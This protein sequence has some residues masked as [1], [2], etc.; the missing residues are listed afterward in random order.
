M[1]AFQKADWDK[2]RQRGSCAVSQ[3]RALWTEQGLYIREIREQ[4]WA[5]ESQSESNSGRESQ[6]EAKRVGE[7]ASESQCEPERFAKNFSF[8]LE[9]LHLWLSLDNSGSLPGSLWKVKLW[10]FF[11]I[12]YIKY[13]YAWWLVSKK[14]EWKSLNKKENSIKGLGGQ[15]ERQSC[16]QRWGT[17]ASLSAIST[18][19][20]VNTEAENSKGRKLKSSCC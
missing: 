17:F 7:W 1:Q 12:W 2:V 15:I 3:A 10:C 19:D 5:G 13:I 4:T 9:L 20:E 11:W 6:W 14:K 8:W 18:H 16:I